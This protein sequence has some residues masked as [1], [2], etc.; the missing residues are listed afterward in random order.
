MACC[1]NGERKA[2]SNGVDVPEAAKRCS[3]IASTTQ[4]LPEFGTG[5]LDTK[6]KLV[7]VLSVCH[8]SEH[9]LIHFAQKS[10]LVLNTMA[11]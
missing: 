8:L 10:C 5:D 1:T 11:I 6:S 7:L 4:K 9:L 3:I 2:G